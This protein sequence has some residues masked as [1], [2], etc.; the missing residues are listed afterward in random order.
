[1]L[2]SHL[3]RVA[4]DSFSKTQHEDHRKITYHRQAGKFQQFI[5]N[6][7]SILVTKAK[8]RAAAA[9]KTEEPLPKQQMTS[10]YDDEDEKLMRKYATLTGFDQC[11]K[12]LFDNP[13]LCDY[14]TFGWLTVEALKLAKERRVSFVLK[15]LLINFV[16]GRGSGFVCV[17]LHHF[18]VFAQVSQVVER[19]RK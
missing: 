12:F 3:L 16:L 15:I 9:N 2:G 1:M 19:S 13:D 4:F 11:E 8:K 6:L 10:D 7:N 18:A 17:Q 5:T 14:V